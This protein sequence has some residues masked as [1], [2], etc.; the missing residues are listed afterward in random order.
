MIKYNTDNKLI[1]L[2]ER[3]ALKYL[4][5]TLYV[6]HALYKFSTIYSRTRT[7][8]SLSSAATTTIYKSSMANNSSLKQDLKN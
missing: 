4:V 8:I 1:M 6:Q 3:Y 5:C 2:Y 7:I